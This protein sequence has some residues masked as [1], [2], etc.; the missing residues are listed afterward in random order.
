[1]VWGVS[2]GYESERK[3]AF[4]LYSAKSRFINATFKEASGITEQRRR[5][6]KPNEQEQRRHSQSNHIVQ[7]EDGR[8]GDAE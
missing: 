6:S 2:I 3:G 4:T 7:Y 8:E 5:T 1:M